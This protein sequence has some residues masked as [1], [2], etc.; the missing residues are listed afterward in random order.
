MNPLYR[1][2]SSSLSVAKRTLQRIISHGGLPRVLHTSPRHI[3][4]LA[5]RPCP[6]VLVLA[7]GEPPPPRKKRT[8]ASRV[9]FCGRMGRRKPKRY[10]RKRA[11][12]LLLGL[13]Q[14]HKGCD[15]A[16][17]EERKHS[18][19]RCLRVTLHIKR[20]RRRENQ[21]HGN[22]FEGN[23]MSSAG[24]FTDEITVHTRLG[25]WPYLRFY[26]TYSGRASDFFFFFKV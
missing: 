10:L 17:S 14:T 23:A 4:S 24:F 9:P 8:A 18:K 12:V 20:V 2:C 11:D 19:G 25:A 22:T 7:V 21:H 1:L 3:L 6:P 13:S 26:I 5:F 16:K 15:P